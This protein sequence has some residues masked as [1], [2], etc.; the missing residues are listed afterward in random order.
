MTDLQYLMDM[1][2]AALL[3]ERKRRRVDGLSEWRRMRIN[4]K[5]ACQILYLPG[6]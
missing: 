4:E 1:G 5:W 2:C 3:H 6:I